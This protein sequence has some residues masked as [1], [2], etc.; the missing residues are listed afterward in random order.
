[1]VVDPVSPYKC[2]YCS[3]QSE[4]PLA[5][6]VCL[7][8]HLP[9]P[10]TPLAGEKHGEVDYFAFLAAP[11]RFIQD[12]PSL[13]KRFYQ[14]SRALHPDRFSAASAEVK[15]ASLERMSLLNRAYSTL[16]T[17]VKLRDYIL[18]LEGL[19]VSAP[20][21]AS[22]P[23][24]LAEAWF[25]IQDL[26]VDDPQASLKKLNE[27]S[28]QLEHRKQQAEKSLQVLENSYDQKPTRDILKKLADEMQSQSYLKSI[29]KD[30]ERIK[31]NVY[32][33]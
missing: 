3:S 13:E 22:I 7:K 10:V 29:E 15:L 14:I 33:D 2:S 16:K 26:L 11:R 5:Q 17:P 24:E 4:D 23:M 8:C 28:E 25:E 19:K 18:V 12:Y 6:H 30:V 9:Q 27:F 31:K 21:K 20:V 32:S 1:M